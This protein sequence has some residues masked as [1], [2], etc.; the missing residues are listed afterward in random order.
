MT[1]R[2]TRVYK[3][4]NGGTIE[5]ALKEHQVWDDFADGYSC[6]GAYGSVAE[7][8]TADGD[9]IRQGMT[10]C[11]GYLRRFYE[12]D[13]FREADRRYWTRLADRTCEEYTDEEMESLLA[14]DAKHRNSEIAKVG[15]RRWL[16]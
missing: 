4:R 3:V 6:R 11:I 13:D 14:S 1:I 8:D 15:Y 2:H 9:V 5:C 12:E 10:F 7:I 16:L